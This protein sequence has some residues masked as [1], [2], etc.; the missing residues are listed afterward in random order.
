MRGAT[1][2]VGAH[3]I[4]KFLAVGCTGLIVNNAVL[5]T[6]YELLRLPLTLA[7]TLATSLAIGN[8]FLLNDRWTFKGH[9]DLSTIE[10]FARFGLISVTGLL[11]STSTLWV[12]V[13]YFSV[14]FLVANLAGIALSTA[15]NFVANARWT[16]SGSLSR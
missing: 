6:S 11:V 4:G 16:W 1:R 15:S 12:L 2:A 5:Y 7:S 10:A 14:N 8:N 9:R 3:P 13:T